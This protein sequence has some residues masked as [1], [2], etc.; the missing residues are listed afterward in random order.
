[1]ATPIARPGND[2]LFLL[3]NLVVGLEIVLSM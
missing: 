3:A 1:M 2:S